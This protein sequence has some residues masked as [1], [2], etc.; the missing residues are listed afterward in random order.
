MASKFVLGLDYGTDSVRA[1]LVDAANG[2]E[3]CTDVCEYPRWSAGK[4][5]D[6]AA[7]Q[8]RQHP[9][10]YLDS[11]KEVVAGC[12][13]AAPTGAGAQVIGLSLD[14]TGSTPVAVDR[15][16]VALALE[17]AFADNP[18]AMF[19]LWKDHTAVREADRI[20]Q[21][22]RSWGGE[23]YTR[24]EG[25][26]YS[27]EWFWSKI[28][29]VLKA[30]AAVRQAAWSWVEHCDWLPAVLVGDTD[31]A[32]LKRGRCAAGHKAMWHGSWGGLP[33]EEFLTAVDP[34][35]AGLRQRL[36]TDTFTADTA[37]G[38]LAPAWAADLGLPAGIPVGVGAFD[39]HMG[40]VG[41]RIKP[42]DLTKVMGTST[43]D[44]A[45]ASYEDMED[46]L[47]RGICGQVDGSVLPGLVGLEA[48]QSAFGDLYA[49]F[50]QLINW[51]VRHLLAAT[52]R[53]PAEARAA[54]ADEV[55]D[56]T[57]AELERAARGIPAG[58]SGVTA[59]DWINGRRTP[60]ADQNLK[61]AMTG[62]SMGTDAPRLY[63][64]L[65]E[66]TAFGARRIVERFEDEGVAIDN[67]VAIGGIAKK[68]PFVM[69]VC[70]DV[71]NRPIQVAASDQCCALGAAIFAATIAG[72]YPSV[73]AAQAA[74]GSG[75]AAT[76]APDP[77]AAAAYDL[78]Y[79]R[80]GALGAYV[81]SLTER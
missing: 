64:A 21:V 51:P 12:L 9:L 61:L 33:P 65:V 18:N 30:D 74:L 75:L 17:P 19:V 70:A 50:R 27:S 24:Y 58:Q 25:G 34:L 79:A 3:V 32:R 53:I 1:V 5:C 47:I 78:L 40:A 14:T 10:D 28:L 46:K 36:F 11:L 37:A 6:A 13:R 72:A 48:G 49:W 81:E 55:E 68:S 2:E 42:G 69:Q 7:N 39:C 63:R 4:Y 67:I 23:D 43:C 60:D 77:G 41:A 22:A 45:V 76:Y 35:L 16:G 59:V 44:I 73:A 26:I 29:H 80:Y 56:R 71:L 20:N 8:F 66:A 31:P 15:Q 38:R 52:G 57:L 54:L 62:L